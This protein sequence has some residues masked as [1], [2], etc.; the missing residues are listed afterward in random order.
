MLGTCAAVTACRAPGPETRPA[1]NLPFDPARRRVVATT[2]A[3]ALWLCTG[4]AGARLLPTPA[5]TRGPFYP[6]TLPLDRDNDLVRVDGREGMAQGV[7]T[8]VQGRILDPSGQPVDDAVV[9]IWQ[10]DAHGRYIHRLDRG[11]APRDPDFQGF[12]S[13]TTGTNGR[14]RFRTI[15]PVPYPGRTPHIHFRVT[16]PGR[17]ELVTQMYI[18]GHPLNERDG[19]F[20][21]TE[22]RERLAVAFE[23]S[24]DPAALQQARFE[25]VLPR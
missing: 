13:F 22:G 3:A 12:G 14:Y 20:R 4:A 15:R 18:A 11:A 1:M 9:E 8:D 7:I 6:D 21:R 19:I 25:I 10:C 23:P 2:G 24:A 17:R 16:A 5:Q